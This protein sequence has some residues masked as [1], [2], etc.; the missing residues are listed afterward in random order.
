MHSLV[1]HII[2]I[3]L[4]LLPYSIFA[5]NE[6]R[7]EVGATIVAS[8]KATPWLSPS[9]DFAFG[10]R[11]LEQSLF[12]LSIWFYKLRD[13][14]VV[15]YANQ[16]MPIS[17][18][19]KVE[20]NRQMGLVLYDPEGKQFDS[21]PEWESF[22]NPT[23]T[24]LPTQ[25]LKSG[26]VL[27]SRQSENNFTRGRFQFRL[28]GDGNL[29]LNTRDV[30][31]D[32][33]YEAYYISGTNDPP[34]S[35]N[36]GYQVVFNQTA[37]MY[38]LRRNNLRKDLTTTS[39]FST[40][41]YYH[42]STLNFDGVFA[43]YSHPK[44]FSVPGWITIWIQPVNICVENTVKAAGSGTCGFKSL[45]QL[46][47]N[48]RPVCECPQGDELFDPNDKYGSCEPNFTQICG[49]D[50]SKSTEDLYDLVAQPTGTDW[51][52]N[53]YEHMEPTTEIACKNSCLSDCF[54]AVAVFRDSGCWKKKLPLSNGRRDAVVNLNGK[55]FLKVHKGNIPPTT[56]QPHLEPHN[57]KDK[58]T[59]IVVE[60][61]LLVV[62]CMGFFLIYHKKIN[63]FQ[64]VESD[65]E[66]N[67]RCFT[68]KELQE[69]TGGF[70]EELGRGAFGIVYK[71]EIVNSGTRKFIAVKRLDAVIQDRE[72]EFKTEVKVI[73]Q[74]HHK[75]LVRL[76]GFCDEGDS[77]L[78]VYEFL[79]NGSL[80]SFLF[81]DTKLSWNI[82]TQIATG[83]ARGLQYLHE[84]CSTQ[85]IHCD[86]KPQ[87][88]LLDDYY[89]AR[90]SDFG[91]AKLLMMNQ[92]QTNTGIRGTKGYVA[93]EWFKGKPITT[94]VDVYSFG[95]M[96]L[97]IV[98]CRRNIGDLEDGGE[99]EPILT[100]WAYDCFQERVLDLL[101]K[102]DVEALNDRKNLKRFVTVALC[103]IQEDASLSRQ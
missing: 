47:E 39:L 84:E 19:S 10:F 8:D 12:L 91:L 78:L 3:M 16:S 65:A 42:R 27:Y 68:Y 40:T 29:V 9:N 74:T 41:D 60:S 81:G 11:K 55:A 101:V 17:K 35:A 99:Q 34:N 93:P 62:I 21:S 94:K 58:G 59:L 95:V 97:E 15:W 18:G 13:K 61:V 48:Q 79:S 56:F 1:G 86:I 24:M 76:L 52:F 63:K 31:S 80:A 89:I 50:N 83:I 45:C 53:D 90:I 64:N 92:S 71:G 20:L 22:Q 102:D 14:T 5:Q 49:K 98:C 23:D 66:T 44:S 6:G 88:I 25:I 36:S 33:S 54:C 75:N 96:L 57:K 87:N 2:F 103:C 100:D 77:K 85:I 82:R 70:K 67:L 46:N 4:F 7:V 69:A 28:L 38:I 43:Q 30:Q 37:Q 26:G 72:R 73:G 51:P 32:F